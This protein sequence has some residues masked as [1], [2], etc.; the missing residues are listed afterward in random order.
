M[1][2]VPMKH[3][4]LCG[5][6]KDRK[7]I[8]ELLQR[9]GVVEI[10]PCS[11]SGDGYQTPDVTDRLVNFEQTIHI[12]NQ[13]LAILDREAPA[14]SSPLASLEGRQFMTLED[15]ET[16]SQD[17]EETCR[18]ARHL[19]E[20]DRQITENRAEALKCRTQQEM[21]VPWK[22]LDV[23]LSTQGT[24]DTVVLIGSLPEACTA[25]DILELLARE[26]PQASVSLEILHSSPQQTCLFL[27][28]LKEDMPAVLDSLNSR[29]FA[30]P[31]LSG[32]ESPAAM[33]R[34]LEKQ[35]AEYEEQAAIAQ[36]ELVSCSGF[37]DALRFTA[38]YYAMRVEKYQVIG[39]S[40]ESK[41]L[42]FLT[43]YLPEQVAAGLAQE[44]E[45]SFPAAVQIESPPEGETPPVLL[46]NNNFNSPVE[47][48]VESYGLPGNGERDPTSVM[49][50]FYYFL[51][52]LMLSDAAYGLIMVI[53]TTLLM[54]K[55]P[56]ME[57]GMR[58]SLRMFRFCG[59]STIG[60]GVL[61][62]SYMGD[63]PA[64]IASTFFGSDFSIPPLWFSPVD[65]PM[66][67]LMFSF[68]IGIVHIFVGL[69]VKLVNDCRDGHVKDAVY[70][71]VFWY[72]LVGGGIVWL[73]TVPAFLNMAGLT[74]HLP[75]P[76]GTVAA[77][78]AGVGA[79][80]IILTS[81]RDSKNPVKRLLK[82]LYGLYNVTGYLSDILSYSRLLA[83][84]L[85]T[86][87]IAT[88]FNKMGSM[89]GGGIAG[90][91]LFIVVFLIGHLL[92]IGINLLGAYVHTNRLQ[93]VEFFGKFYEGGGKKFSPFGAH[94]RYYKFKEDK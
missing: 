31:A 8:L 77:V 55:F 69:G 58:Q 42:F 89:M 52:G 70:D 7:A 84:G 73:L 94:T 34:Q 14:P 46:R 74:F 48:V 16:F 28:C 15:Y 62:G 86:G 53:A 51:F 72:L 90:A 39:R 92:N 37:R 75:S 78:C 6:K 56:R 93:F 11:V 64:I 88:V 35:A 26:Q 49:A 71:V 1:A 10:T 30:R 44:I 83:L 29:G 4:T 5:M 25:S 65:E 87:V 36:K 61:F 80:G 85:A 67:M 45:S 24:R 18:V 9:R 20:L 60:W 19:I 76:V 47:S 63:A 91:I 82:G 41:R 68:L 32:E 54:R 21:L 66:R 23:P 59:I 43:G 33:I 50:I 57:H 13:A 3:L 17:Q 22:E 40:V 27:L 2:V 12:L 38:D 81:G 79:L